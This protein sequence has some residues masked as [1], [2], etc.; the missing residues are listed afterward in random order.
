MARNNR[1]EET[2]EDGFLPELR[3]IPW[4][5]DLAKQGLNPI[6]IYKGGGNPPLLVA[7]AESIRKP[8][9]QATLVK[10]WKERHGR[11]PS[12][13]LIVVH[14]N[15]GLSDLCGPLG[16]SPPVHRNLD[17]GSVERLCREALAQPDR[18][19]AL[20]FLSQVLPSLETEL[21]GINNVGLLALHE[22]QQGVGTRE[23]W[24]EAQ[25]N[26]KKVLGKNEWEMLN[27]LGY[28]VRPNDN[29][30]KFLYGN[31]QKVALA[32]VLQE[33]ETP[34]AGNERFK[35]LSPVSYAFK[36]AD[37]KELKWVIMTQ[38]TRIRIYSTTILAG[39]GH[40]GRT[41][42]Y[43]ECQTSVLSD[44]H[45]AYLWLIY[46]S[47]ALQKDGS[48][49]KILDDSRRF[50]G[51]LA[52]RLRERI[53][54][55]VVPSLA[56]G[57]SAARNQ[58][59]PDAEELNLTYE[60]ALTILFRLLFIAYAE[61]RDLLPYN[62]SE[63]YRR[64]SLKRKA[65]E[66][67][68]LDTRK[69]ND[70]FGNAHW[71]EASQLWQA[72]AKGN[73]E[74]DVP[75]YNGA[76]FSDD[77][78]ISKA[79][80]ELTKIILPNCVFVEALKGLLLIEGDGDDLGPVDFRSL[81]VREF[82][83]VYEGLLESELSIAETDLA[84]EKVK[85][86]D[87]YVP[88]ESGK[89]TEVSK[90][91]IYL[92]NKSGARRSTGSYYT[93]QFAVAHLLDGA[94]EHALTD[95][96]VRLDALT[97][98]E[99]S[100][101]FFDFRVADIAMGSGHFL[102][103]AVDRIEKRMA[104]YL[105]NRTLNIVR[106][107]LNNLRTIAM[108]NLGDSSEHIQIEDGP[109]LRRLIA[110]RCIFGVD[111]NELSVNLARLS[112]WI[113]SFVPGLPLS[114]LDR[115]LVHGN[116]LVG[117]GSYDE[118]T[119]EF[120]RI[121]LGPL[122]LGKSDLLPPVEPL[123]KL[124]NLNDATLS[125]IE[126][127]RELKK[128]V[129][130]AL[131]P[132]KEL[133]DIIAAFHISTDKAVT[134]FLFEEWKDL[135][136]GNGTNEAVI[137]ARKDLHG[138]FPLHFLLAFPEVFMLGR[139]GF[140]VILGNP[141]WKKPKIAE[142]AFWARHFP[143]LRGLSQAK[144]EEKLKKLRN[145]RPDLVVLFEQ[146]RGEMER[147]RNILVRGNYPGMST[148]DPDLYKAFCWRFWRLAAPIG[149][150]IGVVLPRSALIKKGASEF[151]KKV[152][153]VAELVEITVL[154]NN[155]HWVFP[156]I[157]AQY[158]S[159]LVCISRLPRKDRT[160]K[161]NGPFSSE[162][163]FNRGMHDNPV[164]ID[165]E[166]LLDWSQEASVPDLQDQ[167]AVEI[168][169]AFNKAPRLGDRGI[170]P[171]PIGLED[172]SGSRNGCHSPKRVHGAQSESNS[173]FARPATE[174]HA[175]AQ[176]HFMSFSVSH[177]VSPG[178]VYWPVYKG[179]SFNIWEPDNGAETYLAW[180]KPEPVIEWLQR[181]RVRARTN[182]RSPHSEFSEEHLL[183]SSTLPCYRPRI[184]YR[185]I[186][187]ATNQRSIVACLVPGK[188]FLSHLAPYLLWPRGDAKD[189]AFLLGLL[190]SIPVDWYA[191]RCIESGIDM[192][193]FNS[194]PIPRPPRKDLTWKQIVKVAGRLASPDKRFAD[195]ANEVGVDHGELTPIEKS[196]LIYK[197]DALA[198]QMY[199][200]SERQLLH[201][202]ETFHEGSDF[203]NRVMEVVRHYRE[204]QARLKASHNR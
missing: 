75:V 83:T 59:N 153:S 162:A 32:V 179:E 5:A 98:V 126:E 30:T 180:A 105:S 56:M 97:D 82:G 60:M 52:T 184:A 134:G 147:I 193:F 145:Q 172:P 192:Y 150:R 115:N 35:G 45:L 3:L 133:L 143:G 122:L 158:T 9:D 152:F 123:M 70:K 96:F 104:E 165:L 154:K 139:K 197:L 170:T 155:R 174:L 51:D 78:E 91:Q 187:H 173:W 2:E 108:T 43:V 4:K 19:S 36:Q 200:I 116:S 110:R 92:H 90:G 171:P 6:G 121:E 11:R 127:A 25:E 144:E 128:E 33:T 73:P 163:D 12:P 42:T 99:A 88:V 202:F 175:T 7:R 28:Q 72:I 140:D 22:L 191:R 111:I 114:F 198:A 168:F 87:V 61:D 27:S 164:S 138:M 100:E 106:K 49:S 167:D 137:S 93:K 41:D 101:S 29:L 188:I 146:E 57:I 63:S 118:L 84:L 81:G 124:A 130:K 37:D 125:D 204:W 21:P 55:E 68:E 69:K 109:L 48:L 46:S 40:R 142:N 18:N 34:E 178:T 94:L 1:Q 58:D 10:V 203:D 189:Q 76:L 24:D 195:W 196:E 129:D 107:E 113:H 39:V 79:G 80:H 161:L 65:L 182:A 135:L 20:R 194:L 199:G 17:T 157:H 95:H 44:D 160:L 71:Q 67:A 86:E 13:L 64:H 186:T 151:R 77:I 185:S 38:G 149:G 23:G 183:D 141:P 85:G 14:Q 117:A 74:W 159:S 54:D 112:L 176:K 53:Y 148:G 177:E 120:N 31:D 181:K 62:S 166:E 8:P 132:T 66:L 103:E 102:I 26:A 89:L 136:D 15:N 16:E 131:G 190:S 169:S 156:E 119:I 201:I 50:A 47:E